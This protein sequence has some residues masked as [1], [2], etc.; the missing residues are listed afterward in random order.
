MRHIGQA[1]V[2]AASR[3]PRCFGLPVVCF[4]DATSA[5]LGLFLIGK[6]GNLASCAHST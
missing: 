3:T 4:P 2:N 5:R 6:E 1:A